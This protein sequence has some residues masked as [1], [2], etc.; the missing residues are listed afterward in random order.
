MLNAQS[1]TSQKMCAK[2]GFAAVFAAAAFASI[3]APHAGTSTIM[4]ACH[5][6][7]GSDTFNMSCAP[8]ALTSDIFNEQN[9]VD[10]TIPGQSNAHSSGGGSS[11]G[12]ASA[13]HAMAAGS[14][15]AMHVS[16]PGPGSGHAGFAPA[17][18]AGGHR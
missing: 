9:E 5:D 6:S 16:A 14:S 7:G 18:H 13:T 15:G 17:A 10:A 2:I 4:A 3:A 8:T 1:R 12:G 11:S